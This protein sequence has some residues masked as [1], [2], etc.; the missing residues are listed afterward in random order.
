MPTRGVETRAIE[1]E[2]RTMSFHRNLTLA[3]AAAAGLLL[4]VSPAHAQLS[5][6]E[7]GFLGT[8]INNDLSKQVQVGMGDTCLYYGSNDGLKRR[9]GPA[10]PGTICDPNLQFP[11]GIAFST[12]GSFGSAMYVAD[13]SVDNI[14]RSVGCTPGTLF[15]TVAGPGSIAFPPSGT[16]YGDYLYACAVSTGPIYRINSA[17]VRSTWLA[18][19]TAY[20]GFG[21]G[22]AWGMGLYATEQTTPGNGNIVRVSSTGVVSPLLSGFYIPEGFDWGFDGDLFATD[23]GFGRIMRVK[24]DGTATV[25]ATLPGAA[26]VAFRPSEQALYVVSN[27][28]GFYR[29]VRHSTADVSDATRDAGPLAVSPNPASGPCALRYSTQMGGLTRARVVDVAG[30]LVR[31]L[32]DAWRPAGVQSLAWDGRDD[33]GAPVSPGIYFAHVQVAGESRTARV[34]I[35]R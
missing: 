11:V 1:L 23:A 5:M 9:C 6:V 13:Y 34:T 33:A 3:A 2:G 12:G 31:R 18:L 21:R 32:S 10:D 4:S 17:G 25:F 35:V 20:L 19:N 7:S 29:I 8:T 28:G 22:G 30:R 26:D 14:W 16:A 27:Q 24:V 15:A